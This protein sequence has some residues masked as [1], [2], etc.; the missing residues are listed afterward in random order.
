MAKIGIRILFIITIIFLLI[1]SIIFNLFKCYLISNYLGVICILFYLLYSFL[2]RTN[3]FLFNILLIIYIFS[4]IIGVFLIEVF[5]KEIYLVELLMKGEQIGSTSLIVISHILFLETT[6]LIFIRSNKYNK[7]LNFK[8]NY[9]R[10]III[11]FLVIFFMLI[12]AYLYFEIIK[13]GTSL[14]HHVNKF[15]YQQRFMNFIE[16]K[17]SN[18]LWVFPIILGYIFFQKQRK[19]SL[20]IYA[21]VNMYFLFI[22]QKFS[23][24]IIGFYYFFLNKITEVNK[25]NKKIFFII[26]FLSIFLTILVL[27]QYK[28]NYSQ[29]SW[30]EIFLHFFGRIAQQGQLWWATYMKTVDKNILNFNKIVDE[31]KLMF[32]EKEELIL[33]TGI[34]KIMF[35]VAPKNIVIG[36]Y[37][38]GIR[39]AFS[40]QA[41]FLYYFSWIGLLLVQIIYGFIYGFILKNIKECLKKNKLITLIL[42]SRIYLYAN[43]FYLQSDFY[44]ILSVKM[45]IVYII[46]FLISKLEEKYCIKKI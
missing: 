41:S 1:F 20:I 36:A 28:N 37:N 14:S 34:Y 25:T 8:Y 4:N 44:K 10:N 40:T 33:N 45:F 13:D 22:G 18:L 29:K 43:Q 39:Y 42:F 30:E 16:L 27:F 11:N 15:Q 6:Y 17:L 24:F 32:Y 21:L 7:Y 38:R 46:I 9:K 2:Y 23:F 3:Y 12:L 5:N 35:L 19:Y 26:S 31:L